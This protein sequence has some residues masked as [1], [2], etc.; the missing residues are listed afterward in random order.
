ALIPTFDIDSLEQ[1]DS[2]AET[3]QQTETKDTV[4]WHEILTNW[5]RQLGRNPTDDELKAAWGKI[6]DQ[7]LNDDG[8]KLLRENLG[9][10][11]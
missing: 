1:Q 8:V 10:L 2:P 4:N 7:Q 3:P 5:V 11:K 9:L 6:T